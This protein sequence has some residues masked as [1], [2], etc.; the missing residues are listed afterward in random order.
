MLLEV[1]IGCGKG[2]FLVS[3]ALHHPHI[4]F[5]GV[6]K[7]GRFLRRGMERSEKRGLSNLAFVKGDV[8][9]FLR[10]ELGPESVS[11]FHVY[12]PDP[13]PKRR[14]RRRR[15]LQAEFLRLL[16][17]RLTQGG[18]IEV[19]T[20]D[21][22]YFEAIKKTA[23]ACGIAWGGIRESLNERLFAAVDKTNY[24]LKYQKEARPIYYLEL[25]K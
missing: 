4:R 17:D 18:L 15:L 11:V 25:Q 9:V 23:P 8:R 1:E 6:D 20:D 2:K 14:H 3:R 10:T 19:A 12:F 13:W 7:A 16:H 5:L 24:E 22:D 21:A